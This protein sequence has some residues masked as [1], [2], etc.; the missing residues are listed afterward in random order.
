[1]ARTTSKINRGACEVTDFEVS[2][3]SLRNALTLKHNL[4]SM[5]LSEFASGAV[6]AIALTG[7]GVYA[8]SIIKSQMTF[9]SN[10]MLTVMMGASASSA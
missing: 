2:V 5:S 10:T 4:L 7:S 3:H 1:M 8:P 9:S 6:F